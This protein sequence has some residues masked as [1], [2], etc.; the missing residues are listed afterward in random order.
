MN[1]DQA[2]ETYI[3]ESRDL[4]QQME[5]TLLSFDSAGADAEAVNAL[6]RA[7]H[8]I[9]GSA[10]LFSLDAIV[11]F[12]HTVES[13]LDRVRDG[14]L[15]INSELSAILLESTDHI[16]LL[17]D[18]LSP[19]NGN[20]AQLAK[21]GEAIRRRLSAYL[22]GDEQSAQVSQEGAVTEPKDESAATGK[23]GRA[24]V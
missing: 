23:I 6:F 22:C 17:V 5:Q 4:L 19:G 13:V 18:D 14:S 12:T 3:A 9:K 16:S 11:G 21:A 20:E 10:G 1:L 8:T 2:L 7:A 15:S 24:H